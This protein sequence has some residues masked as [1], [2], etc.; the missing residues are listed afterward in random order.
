MLQRRS[1]LKR[2]AQEPETR[3]SSGVLGSPSGTGI[4]TE[5]Q[6]GMSSTDSFGTPDASGRDEGERAVYRQHLGGG[7]GKAAAGDVACWVGLHEVDASGRLSSQTVTLD[8]AHD[9]ALGWPAPAL[10]TAPP[11]LAAPQAGVRWLTLPPQPAARRRA[12]ERLAGPL[13]LHPLAARTLIGADVGH[14]IHHGINAAGA[15]ALVETVAPG[16][17]DTYVERTL[18]LLVLY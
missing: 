9:L 2:H 3:A 15:W 1:S 4:G 8:E 12:V 17:G 7:A 11:S 18:L 6:D 13:A 10:P 16:D 5:L 14:G